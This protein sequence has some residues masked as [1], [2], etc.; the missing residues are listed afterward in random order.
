[1]LVY[2]RVVVFPPLVMILNSIIRENENEYVAVG[3]KTDKCVSC[4][5]VSRVLTTYHPVT[6]RYF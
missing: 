4:L 3:P 2:Q 5:D 6:F 1:M